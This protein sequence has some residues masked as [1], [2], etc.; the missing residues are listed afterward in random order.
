MYALKQ[1][2]KKNHYTNS[3][4]FCLW[5]NMWSK[6]KAT[7]LIST[8]TSVKH[9]CFREVFYIFCKIIGSALKQTTSYT[10]NLKQNVFISI[11]IFSTLLNSFSQRINYRL[12]LN[13]QNE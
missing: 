9:E 7:H 11:L 6:H 3:Q 4:F 5:D 2:S 13:P 10:L 12:A 8:K 1:A